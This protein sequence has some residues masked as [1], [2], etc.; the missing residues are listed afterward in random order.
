MVHCGSRKFGKY[1]AQL[2]PDNKYLTEHI[3]A[4]KWA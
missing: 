1:V 4:I 3:E 2:N